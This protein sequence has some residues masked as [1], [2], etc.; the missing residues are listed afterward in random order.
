M[1]ID[2]EFEQLLPL[3]STPVELHD[4][5][6][7]SRRRFLQGTL[8][9]A[10]AA[11]LASGPFANS[12]FAA[13]PI[14]NSEGVLVIVMLGGGNDGLNTL[15]PISGTDR[16]RY[17]TLRGNL[18]IPAAQLL[19]AAQDYGFHPRLPRLAARF[20]TGRVAVV[21]GVGQT[22]L[23]DLS[24]FTSMAS[25]M[26]GTASAARSSGWLGRYLDGLSEFD[27]GFRGLTFSSSVPLHLLGQRAKVTA[28]PDQGGMW[29]SDRTV[30]WENRAFAAVS[31]YASGPTGLSVWGDRIA[32]NGQAALGMAQTI[33]TLYNPE[34]TT[35]GLPHDLTLAARLVNANLGARVIGVS[36][37]GSF[38]TH[39]NQMYDHGELMGQLDA[40]IEAFFTTLA[41]GFRD[42]VTL[43]T[44]SE[45]GRRPQRNDS[46]GT[47]HG[48]A[49]VMLVVGENVKG[50]LHGAQ[51]SL[52]TFDQRSNLVAEVDYRQVYAT[53][54]DRWL[55]GD[56]DQLLGGNYAQL[57]LFTNV[58][59]GPRVVLPP[60][61][62][63]NPAKPFPD[64]TALVRQQYA[65][66]LL[67][68]DPGASS[69]TGW[70]GKLQAGTTTPVLL[71]TT[72]MGSDIAQT[73]VHPVLRAYQACFGRPPT[74][75]YLATRAA[76]LE[77]AGLSK[78]CSDL[79][80]ST[81]FTGSHPSMSDADF[82][83]W[84]YARAFGKSAPAT[85][86]V[87][88]WASEIRSRRRTRAG[89]LAYF[90]DHESSIS[91]LSHHVAVSMLY[92]QMLHKAPTAARYAQRIADLRNG[93][94]LSN[95]V[96][97]F[98]GSATYQSRFV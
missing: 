41:P 26:A 88:H 64:W 89:V 52:T 71:I 55:D 66:L 16:S 68:D 69:V 67:V 51:P 29:G 63:P 24:H 13:T 19:P 53:L 91:Y 78:V 97:E 28:L 60:P 50:G 8:A 2:L 87:T 42:Q 76:T 90:L 3:L 18:A 5:T 80:A 20:A 34:V 95:L 74:A 48:T 61:P 12:A 10:G 57:D 92:A 15:A 17:Q 85:A 44:F 81:T 43:A 38:D 79:M 27:S 65:D 70:V 56:P 14:A 96:S 98:L 84:V 37:S 1:T 33:N 40:G 94:P 49:S 35:A 9:T 75:A 58:P 93:A 4:P 32:Q 82:V 83:R 86:A 30:S 77:S 73:A 21:R 62:P 47:D 46:N 59:G 11:T 6:G 23:N 39:S 54:L 72:F 31:A 25:F 22:T 36:V 45:F 7:V